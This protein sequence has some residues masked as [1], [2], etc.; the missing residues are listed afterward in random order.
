MRINQDMPPQD[1]LPTLRDNSSTHRKTHPSLKRQLVP[2][3]IAY[4]YIITGTVFVLR[5]QDRLEKIRALG[6][7]S[8]SS[9]ELRFSFLDGIMIH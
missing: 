6:H 5:F 9:P 1:N 3:Q 8:N 2:L 4:N 7:G